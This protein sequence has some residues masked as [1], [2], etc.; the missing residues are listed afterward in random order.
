MIKA[1]ENMIDYMLMQAARLQQLIHAGGV[2]ADA[3]IRN[4]TLKSIRT[5]FAPKVWLFNT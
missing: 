2:L 3:S 1:E 5:V 4:Q